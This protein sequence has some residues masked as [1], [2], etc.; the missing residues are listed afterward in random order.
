MILARGLA[1]NLAPI[2]V[3]TVCPGLGLNERLARSP[4]L[5]RKQTERQLIPCR[6]ELA[7]VAQTYLYL[8]CGSVS[9]L[10]GR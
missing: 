2:R 6:A 7:E 8:M 1:V 10:G 9:A 4:E 5:V 3:N